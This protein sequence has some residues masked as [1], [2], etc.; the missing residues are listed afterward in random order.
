[1][2]V[3]LRSAIQR[4]LF[5]CSS[6]ILVGLLA[7][8]G[9][10]GGSSST[11]T[12]TPTKAPT[13]TP[14]LPPSPTTTLTT[15]TGNGYTVSYPQGW[16]ISTSGTTVTFTD[17]TKIYNFAVVV[18]PDPNG[19]SSP[20]TSVNAGITGVKSRLTNPQTVSLPATTTVGGDSWVQKGVSGNT[21]Q[22]GQNVDIEVIVISDNH[23]ANSPTTNNFTIIYGTAKQLFPTAMTAYFQPMLSSFK[24][25][26]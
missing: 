19:V 26:S 4:V 13:P 10:N 9:G 14:T 3:T 8:C 21:T 2:Y 23:P 6:L 15:Y 16:S 12:P 11:P 1:M 18:S 24:F 22:N 20:D 17:P 5:I 7:A 25:T